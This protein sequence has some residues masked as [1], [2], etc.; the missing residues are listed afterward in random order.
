MEKIWLKSYP[1]GV[2]HDVRPEQFR[3]LTHLLEDSFKK[4]AHKPFSVCLDQWM[5]YAQLD[6][7][8]SSLGE[9]GRASCRE[10]V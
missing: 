3:S 1:Q 4:N 6:D 7:L 8:S 9:I 2:P 5:S 10:R